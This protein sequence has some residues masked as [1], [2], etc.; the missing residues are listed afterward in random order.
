MFENSVEGTIIATAVALWFA[1]GWY[2]NERLKHV[3]RKL[4][5]VLENFDGLRRYLYE[6]DPQFD[7]ERHILAELFDEDGSLFAGQDHSE[8]IDQKTAG[9]K[10]NLNT[11]FNH[12]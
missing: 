4:D 8:L 10:R 11:S 9:G 6:I 3:H 7:D 1:H 2:L 12:Q 5:C